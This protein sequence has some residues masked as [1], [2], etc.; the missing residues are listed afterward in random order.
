MAEVSKTGLPGRL[1]ETQFVRSFPSALP[2]MRRSEKTRLFSLTDFDN[3][4]IKV[5]VATTAGVES[6]RQAPPL[7]LQ[8]LSAMARPRP[9]PSSLTVIA[10][11]SRVG[12]R[13]S[14]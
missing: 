14:S 7:R 8:N 2:G 5:T 9:V 12:S 4:E 3:A 1:S 11:L 10:W 6:F 13:L